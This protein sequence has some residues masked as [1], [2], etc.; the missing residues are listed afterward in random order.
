MSPSTWHDRC[1]AYVAVILS[2]FRWSQPRGTSWTS[3]RE[4]PASALRASAGSEALPRATWN[5]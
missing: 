5:V 4:P 1:A 2:V 3:G